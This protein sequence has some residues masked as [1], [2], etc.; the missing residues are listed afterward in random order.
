MCLAYQKVEIA[1]DSQE[2]QQRRLLNCYK[3]L[4]CQP[5]A[6]IRYWRWAAQ[7]R[8]ASSWFSWGRSCQTLNT[9]KSASSASPSRTEPMFWYRNVHP[10]RL[11]PFFLVIGS[12]AVYL[13][14]ARHANT[15][16]LELSGPLG[17][18]ILVQVH[19]ELALLAV[20]VRGRTDL[21]LLTCWA[22]E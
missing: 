18:S 10:S 20:E 15:L 13:W 1:L 16:N 3:A 8:H 6:L 5:S 4:P 7:I 21:I 12:S 17:D 22:A 2:M 9:G 19:A 14:T 11:T